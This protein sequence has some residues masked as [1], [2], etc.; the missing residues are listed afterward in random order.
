MSFLRPS[1]ALGRVFVL[2][3]AAALLAA[4]QVDTTV[5]VSVRDNG[6]GFQ[7]GNGHVDEDG[8]LAQAAT[9][10]SIRERTTLLGGSLRVWTRAGCGTEV[11]LTIPAGVRTGRHGSDRRMYA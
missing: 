2:L 7:T 1:R 4:C 11:S 6:S 9:P 8:F 3:A 10:W 5:E